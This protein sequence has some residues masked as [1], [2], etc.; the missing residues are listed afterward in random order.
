MLTSKN[1]PNID[2]INNL[3]NINLY[4]DGNLQKIKSDNKIPDNILMQAHLTEFSVTVKYIID[5]IITLAQNTEEKNNKKISD[6][7]LAN[8][9][10][11]SNSIDNI[12][13]IRKEII[14]NKK[15]TNEEIDIVISGLMFDLELYKGA[16]AKINKEET[17]TIYQLRSRFKTVEPAETIPQLSVI[18]LDFLE[19][20]LNN[21]KLANN[22]INP[23]QNTQTDT[24]QQSLTLRDD[25]L[26]LEEEITTL[27]E[28]IK[29]KSSDTKKQ[30]VLQMNKLVKDRA[31]IHNKINT[32]S[33]KTNQTQHKDKTEYDKKNQ[34]EKMTHLVD[35]LCEYIAKQDFDKLKTSDSDNLGE[36]LKTF[37]EE[38]G[39]DANDKKD[40]YCKMSEKIKARWVESKAILDPIFDEKTIQESRKNI[41]PLGEHINNLSITSG[42]NIKRRAEVINKLIEEYP[43]LLPTDCNLYSCKPFFLPTGFPVYAPEKV[44]NNTNP[45]S[46]TISDDTS[47][48]GFNGAASNTTNPIGFNNKKSNKEQD[49]GFMKKFTPPIN[50]FL[51]RY[52]QSPNLDTKLQTEQSYLSQELCLKINPLAFT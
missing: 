29:T 22:F 17:A 12:N 46:L 8:K 33:S 5:K 28:K 38:L 51:D 30:L 11:I 2:F 23:K 18:N 48:V 26:E 31:E 20:L 19:Q 15:I 16:L 24:E 4:Y 7:I 49:N 44:V 36:K 21:S 39:E 34:L 47:P 14:K 40:F 3:F 41:V 32:L 27:R 25:L 13:K 50:S 37:L 9:N 10:K 43:N 1:K 42:I 52:Q 35:K 45:E 6:N